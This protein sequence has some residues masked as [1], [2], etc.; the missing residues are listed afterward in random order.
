MI[1]GRQ[2][3]KKLFHHYFSTFPNRDNLIRIDVPSNLGFIICFTIWLLNSWTLLWHFEKSGM[4][5]LVES[6]SREAAKTTWSN[7]NCFALSLK[8]KIGIR[9]RATTRRE[10]WSISSVVMSVISSKSIA[11]KIRS[12]KITIYVLESLMI[13]P[14]IRFSEL[15]TYLVWRFFILKEWSVPGLCPTFDHDRVS[16]L[17]PRLS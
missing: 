13:K 2:F 7:S 12:K 4:Y 5:L 8:I 3:I 15:Y 14:L 6:V 1:S 11:R 16:R 17:R 10:A 9:R